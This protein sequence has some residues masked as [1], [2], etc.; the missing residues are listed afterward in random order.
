[1]STDT[2]H[3]DSLES[4]KNAL[5]HLGI[6]PN[7]AKELESSAKRQYQR[8][9]CPYSHF[10]VGASILHGEAFFSGCNVENAAYSPC[11]C[12][13]R[14]AIGNLVSSGALGGEGKFRAVLVYSECSDVVSPCGVC[15]Q[16]LREFCAAEI[17]IIMSYANGVLIKTLGELLPWSF[18]PED[19]NPVKLAAEG[20]TAS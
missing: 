14:N 15:R 20:K 16:V 1:M 2:N 17:P 11:L 6:S 12:A 7:E 19:L 5:D 10:R 3:Y 8:A 18:G 13:E 4:A 9:Y